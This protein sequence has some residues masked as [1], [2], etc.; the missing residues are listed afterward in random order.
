LAAYVDI[1]G[2]LNDLPDGGLDEGA[3]PVDGVAEAEGAGGPVEVEAAA[4]GGG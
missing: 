3:D 2:I 4:G 1:S